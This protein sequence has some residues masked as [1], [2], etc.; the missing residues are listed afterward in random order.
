MRHWVSFA[1]LAL[2]AG[3]ANAGSGKADIDTSPRVFASASGKYWV[4]VTTKRGMTSEA[5][6]WATKLSVYHARE[7]A[8]EETVM[9]RTTLDIFPDRMLVSDKGDLI[10]L[11]HFDAVGFQSVMTV[12]GPDGTRR[13]TSR[14]MEF[15]EPI[16]SGPLR[17][18]ANENLRF[19][20]GAAFRYY[21]TDFLVI[22]L[23]ARKVARVSLESGR[24]A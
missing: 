14:F 23:G 16:P 19:G 15:L 24:P 1:L 5:P 13:G 7:G 10:V 8:D 3:L 17:A 2:P 12:Y 18:E 11:G 6:K 9:S 4:K 21:S 22:P 20:K